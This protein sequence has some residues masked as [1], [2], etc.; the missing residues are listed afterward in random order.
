MHKS[1]EFFAREFR[2]SRLIRFVLN[3]FQ[4][5]FDARRVVD[6]E[7]L[8]LDFRRVEKRRNVDD[9]HGWGNHGTVARIKH[10]GRTVQELKVVWETMTM[11][12]DRTSVW[13]AWTEF[14]ITFRT[15]D[16]STPTEWRVG[17]VP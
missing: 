10:T 9:A 12:D 16:R 15:M 11:T 13:M 5:G 1:G 6:T 7:P 14:L 8:V 3:D 2:G 4:N 17:Y